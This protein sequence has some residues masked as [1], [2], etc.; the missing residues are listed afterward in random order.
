MKVIRK[1]FT[2]TISFLIIVIFTQYSCSTTKLTSNKSSDF[3]EK[4]KSVYIIINTA[5]SATKFSK[6]FGEE[7]KKVLMEKGTTSEIYV[8]E[9]LSLD[10]EK[11]INEKISAFNPQVLMTIIQ[12]EVQTNTAYMG[13]MKTF[14]GGVYD[15]KITTPQNETAIWRASLEFS[16]NSPINMTVPGL[17]KDLIKK[18]TKDKLL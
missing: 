14:A 3:N 13:A 16:V 17:V 5:K 1:H 12:T 11:E 6:A 7:F 18:M 4:I 8:I 9:P 2:S 15:I 10:G